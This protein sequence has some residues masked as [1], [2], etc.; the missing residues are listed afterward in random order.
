MAARL[1]H[2]GQEDSHLPPG[3]EHI[4]SL[5]RVVHELT[6]RLAR[7]YPLILG[8]VHHPGDAREEHA[9][10]VRYV[11]F[12]S[13]ADTAV[14]A[15][16]FRWRNRIGRLCGVEEYPYPSSSAYFYTYIRRVA[17]RLAREDPDLVHLHNVSQFVPPLRNTLPRARLVL[18]MHCEWLVELPRPVIARR[19]AA[20]DLVLGVSQHIVR[21]IESAFPEVADRC[22]FSTTA[23]TWR[24]FRRV[25]AW[26]PGGA[27]SSPR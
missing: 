25:S 14:L 21:Q 8:A 10:G 6:V 23:S 24:P 26:R 11:R 3:P 12:R 27:P 1:A 5:T 2:L 19:L 13:G 4:G 9:N 15:S 22:P 17:R 20:V 16:L 18:Q 7:R